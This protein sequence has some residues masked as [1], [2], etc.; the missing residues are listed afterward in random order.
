M[1]L[2]SEAFRGLTSLLKGNHRMA[3]DANLNHRVLIR[4]ASLADAEEILDLQKLAYI[5]EA[6]LYGDY[7]IFSRYAFTVGFVWLNGF[8]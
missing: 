8:H 2:G 6:E 1:Q 5:S 7:S 4:R 3:D